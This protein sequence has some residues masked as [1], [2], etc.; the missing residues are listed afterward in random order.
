MGNSEHCPPKHASELLIPCKYLSK[1]RSSGEE[2]E[3]T[4]K[5]GEEWI[6]QKRGIDGTA[7]AISSE[8]IFLTVT[9][10][11]PQRTADALHICG[12]QSHL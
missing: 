3:E 9:G 5:F 12:R 10:T 6:I 7:I 4:R 8:T 11:G 2:R 1:Q